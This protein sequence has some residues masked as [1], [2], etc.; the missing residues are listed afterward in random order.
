MGQ[1]M[2]EAPGVVSVVMRDAMGGCAYRGVIKAGIEGQWELARV[3]R[4]QG[5]WKGCNRR[6]SALQVWP[7]VM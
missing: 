2:E 4:R 5:P 1:V 7:L 6:R 3:G